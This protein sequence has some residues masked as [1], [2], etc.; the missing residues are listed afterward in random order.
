MA[1]RLAYCCMIRTCCF[2][3]HLSVP[4]SFVGEHDHIV[5]REGTD[6]SVVSTFPF[7]HVLELVRLSPMVVISRRP[8]RN[9]L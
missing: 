9:I 2:D 1:F 7:S 8:P 4:V 3:W 6:D 5:R